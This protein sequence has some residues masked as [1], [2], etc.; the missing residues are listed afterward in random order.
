MP[1]I[2]SANGAAATSFC[3]G[4]MQFGAGSDETQSAAVFD[5]CRTAGINFFDSAWNYNEGRS[6]TILGKLAAKDRADLILTTKGVQIGGASRANILKQFNDSLT[7]LN[8]DYV[9]VYFLH[10]F[11]DNTPLEETFE[12]LAELKQAGKITHIG[13]SN[14]AAWQVMKA[15]AVCAKLGIRIDL[16]Q[17][18]YNLVKRQ[19]EVEILPMCRAED[20]A[21][22]PYSPLGG[23][24][25]SG[26]YA[27]GTANGRIEQNKMY[28]ER[29]S[30]EWM[31]TAA[32]NLSKLAA[33]LGTSPITLAV[34]WVAANPAI[35]APIISGK[36]PEQLAPSLA[37]Y[38][39]PL[40]PETYAALSALTPTPAPATDRLEEAG[41]IYKPGP[42]HA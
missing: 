17:P 16:I 1:V 8:S 29:Y 26:K 35:T 19:A 4:T 39:N 20:I 31:R 2:R 15:Q 24:L 25:L 3:F 11:D 5:Q 42:T 9:D 22:T 21:V 10:V 18:M 13:V 34:Q 41:A 23:G 7:R 14:Y 28:A 37:A 33:E 38:Q 40:D 30:P 36:T 32:A 27:G 6:E 12:T